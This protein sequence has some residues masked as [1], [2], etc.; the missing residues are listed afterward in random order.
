MVSRLSA[1]SFLVVLLLVPV[2]CTIDDLLHEGRFCSLDHAC[3]DGFTCD[4]V[5]S[6]C[7]RVS[8]QDA[9]P[10]DWTVADAPHDQHAGEPGAPVDG[11]I[12]SEPTSWDFT[13][14]LDFSCPGTLVNCGGYCVDIQTDFSHCGGC[15]KPCT[16]GAADRCESG[17]CLCGWKPQCTGGLNC[18]GGYCQCI[19]GSKSLCQGCCL[20]G[21]CFIGDTAAACGT[22]S[23]A[24]KVCKAPDACKL[25]LCKAGVCSYP[26]APDGTPC[27]SGSCQ[28]GT[29]VPTS[30]P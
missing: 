18:S 21:G 25:E 4:P 24:C 30:P 16:V 2:G 20:S 3:S 5:S 17:G 12:S 11:P 23:V 9:R 8:G 14:Q 13:P 1:P 7:V 22:G 29:C 28:G 15:N 10:K 26:N 27:P 6:K 19:T